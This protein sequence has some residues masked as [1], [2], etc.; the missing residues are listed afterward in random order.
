MCIIIGFPVSAMQMSQQQRTTA[1]ELVSKDGKRETIP[2]E[3]AQQSQVLA[4]LLKFEAGHVIQMPEIIDGKTLVTLAQIMRSFAKHKDLQGKALL[5]AVIKD[6]K[7]IDDQIIPLLIAFNFLGFTRG[8]RLIAQYA[9]NNVE[10]MAQIINLIKTH[11]LSLDTANEIAR[12]Y[13]LITSNNLANVDSNSYSFSLNEYLEYQPLMVNER[14]PDH[15]LFLG[16]LR[17]NQLDGL[18]K[19][20]DIANTKYLV[21]SEN[22]LNSIASGSFNGFLNLQTL[23]L[24]KNQISQFTSGPLHGLTNLRSLSL[25]NNNINELKV[26]TFND[27]SNLQD[28]NLSSNFLTTIGKGIFNNLNNLQ[29]LNLSNN[30]LQKLT[31]GM[32]QGLSNLQHLSLHKCN[33]TQIAPDAFHGLANLQGLILSDNNLSQLNA[34]LFQNLTHL[35]FINLVDNFSMSYEN[36]EQLQKDLPNVTIYFTK[37]HISAEDYYGD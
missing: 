21:L 14:K 9:S 7:I 12:I 34:S 5:D 36:L 10:T 6:A 13:Y 11:Q 31:S 4:D 33:L 1:I 8:I 27:V 17:I 28:L 26:G 22:Q 18:S 23:D 29:K 25:A 19:I 35:Q 2:F 3:V 20:S 37:F 15:W 16:E 32:F 24:G 30:P